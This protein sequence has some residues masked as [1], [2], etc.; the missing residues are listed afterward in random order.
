MEVPLNLTKI[1]PKIMEGGRLLKDV[2]ARNMESYRGGL[3]ETVY[4]L[5]I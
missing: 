1:F 2:I 3:A 4:D 5:T